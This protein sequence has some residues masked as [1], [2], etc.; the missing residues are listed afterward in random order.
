[1][2]KRAVIYVRVSSEAQ[3]KNYSLPTQREGCR[4]Y[5]AEHDCTV[6]GEVTD[7]F[8][9]TTIDRPGVAQLK[10]LVRK[11]R[12]DTVIVYDVD[13]FSRE[14]IGQA[15]LEQELEALGARVEYVLG[16]YGDTTEGEL[17][18]HIKG[19]IA[20]YENR[21]RVERSQR[22]KNGRAAAG[23]PLM[24]AGRAPYGYRYISDG[25]GKGHLEIEDP[26]AQVVRDMYR[27]LL[28]EGLSSYAIAQRIWELGIP[29]RG[30]TNPV[31]GARKKKG[32]ADWSPVTIRKILSNPIYKGKWYW[33]KTRVVR[34]GGK[35]VARRRPPEEWIEVE[36]QAIVDEQTWDMAQERL[37]QNKEFA[38]RNARREY[39][40]RGLVF[41]SCGRR[42]VGRYK[43]HLKRA[44]YRCPTS[45]SEP[46]RK[47]C[48]ARFSIRQEILE[49]AV[50]RE[51]QAF[52]LD[53]DQLQAGLRRYFQEKEAERLESEARMQAI[54][55]ALDD[56]DR[57]LGSLLVK[58][59]A[60]EYPDTVLAVEK[61]RLLEQR[62]ELE[63]TRRRL[64]AQLEAVAP[65]PEQVKS[66][67]DFSTKIR[68]GLECASPEKKRQIL[69][70]LHIR[71]DVI[72]RQRVRISGVIS[73]GSIVEM[74]C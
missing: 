38:R 53:P 13:R 14:V 47:A 2:P 68:Q 63:D 31:V 39:L 42:W 28:D 7:T 17:L 25:K 62:G 59:L 22:G 37:R 30:D 35:R 64:Q 43:N 56:V 51:V 10:D 34:Q 41:C 67:W 20:Q 11:E 24:P 48:P 1:M 6:I 46:W 61:R 49:E 3:G 19:A 5:A 40:L 9:G 15:I 32:Y 73:E 55:R 74:Q 57:K 12:A 23:Y 52:L 27:W 50:W 70:L 29:S 58:E 66:L 21:Q 69:E 16:G 44:Y 4:R 33:G 18:K 65:N 8:T 26:E 36:V 72:D 71:V 60:G 45:E 54:V